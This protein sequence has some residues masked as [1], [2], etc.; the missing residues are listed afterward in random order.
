MRHFISPFKIILTAI[1]ITAP[2][3]I[4]QAKEPTELVFLTWPDYIAPEI[5]TEFEQDRNVKIRFVY[6]QGDDTRDRMLLNNNGRGFDLA[7]VSGMSIHTYAKRNWLEPISEK[8]IPNLKHVDSRWC[9]AFKDAERFTVPYSWGTL[10]IAYRADLVPEAITSWKQ[11]FTPPADIGKSIVMIDSG[12]EVIGMALKS[13]G[14]SINTTDVNEIREAEKLLLQQ[15]SFV[16]DYSYITITERSSLVSGDAKMAIAFNGDA[17]AVSEHEP[18]IK[19]VIPEEGSLLWVDYLAVMSASENKKLAFDFINYLN[20][21]AVAAKLALYTSYA[22][23]NK[24]AEKLLPHD[25][26]NNP[27]I[28]PDEAILEMSEA[29]KSLNPKTAKEYGR[30]MATLTR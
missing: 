23:T 13:L 14:Y 16:R 9:T 19:F 11:F 29:E 7:L 15:R 5:V 6:F 22:T 24:A 4:T 21:P 12:R 25:F 26:L 30:I 1:L 8:N 20:K 27:T 3:H 18:R 28:Y 10:G 17:L 2:L